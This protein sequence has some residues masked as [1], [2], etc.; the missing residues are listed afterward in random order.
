MFS[1]DYTDIVIDHFMCPRNVGIIKDPNGEGSVGDP[2]CGD[3]L[4]I[5]IIEKNK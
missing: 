5:Y 1:E 4:N 3:S 2:G